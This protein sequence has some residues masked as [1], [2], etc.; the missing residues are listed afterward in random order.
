MNGSDY[1]YVH[2]VGRFKG[3]PAW[4]NINIHLLLAFLSVGLA[5]FFFLIGPSR[6]KQ[7]DIQKDVRDSKD[8]LKDIFENYHSDELLKKY[9]SGYILF[10]LDPSIN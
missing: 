9:P 10:G 8:L 7:N 2:N 1:C 3:V 6:G 5:V 4:K